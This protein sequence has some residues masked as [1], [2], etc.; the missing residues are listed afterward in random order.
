M[1]SSMPSLNT[2]NLAGAAESF[3]TKVMKGPCLIE[4]DPQITVKNI[5]FY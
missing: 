2:L 5:F 1:A 4:F 3:P